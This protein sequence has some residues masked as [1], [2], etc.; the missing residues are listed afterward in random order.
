MNQNQL[1]QTIKT[2]FEELER[3]VQ[4]KRAGKPSNWD[5]KEWTEEIL[6]TLCH[7]GKEFDFS[8]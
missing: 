6:V 5:N 2:A 3:E 4:H 1:M 7:L 8:A